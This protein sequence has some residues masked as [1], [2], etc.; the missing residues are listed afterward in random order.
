[1][2]AC[3]AEEYHGRGLAKAAVD[4]LLHSFGAPY[5]GA[6]EVHAWCFARNAP[7]VRLWLGAGFVKDEDRSGKTV[8]IDEAKGGGEV[9]EACYI[10]ALQ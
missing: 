8:T 3:L 5:A 4:T 7:S 1:M 6:T 10:W 2:P 9:E